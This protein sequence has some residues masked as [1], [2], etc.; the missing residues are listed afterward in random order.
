LIRACWL[1]RQRSFY[2]ALSYFDIR[3]KPFLKH[4]NEE[5]KKLPKNYASKWKESH[6]S[7]GKNKQNNLLTLA[8]IELATC[9]DNKL[10]GFV[11]QT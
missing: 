11:K 4:I 1:F 9:C 10:G 6:G 3:L 5:N 8:R 7:K 2:I